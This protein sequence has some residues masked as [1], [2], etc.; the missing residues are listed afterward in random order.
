[1][2]KNFIQIL[3][4]LALDKP[5][6]YLAD[7]NIEIGDVVM[8]EF[9]R[10]KI[11][12]VVFDKGKG[13][14]AKEIAIEKVKKVL[15]KSSR[16]KFSKKQLE[17]I[18]KIASYNLASKGLVLRA[19]MGIL[20]SDKVK[21]IPIAKGQKVDKEKFL[22]KELSKNQKE[23]ADKIS[24]S[25]DQKK[26]SISLIDGVTGSGKT[27]VYFSIIAKILSTNNSSQVLILLPEIALTS[28]LL[29]RFEEQFGFKAA[30]WHSKISKK[31]K[32]KFFMA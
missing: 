31:E 4:P 13:E 12:G 7:D 6:T 24:D 25:I 11:W 29:M 9:G 27:E 15:E 5:F 17:F 3:L 19:F 26:P 30:L 21:K 32:E 1:M 20:N 8:V 23:I 22:L 18:E 28:Q 16:L 2:S 14:N 10:K